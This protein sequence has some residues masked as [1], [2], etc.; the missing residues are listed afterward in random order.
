MR[1]K[2]FF[3]AGKYNLAKNA[4]N[5]SAWCADHEKLYFSPAENPFLRSKFYRK[6]LRW[7]KFHKTWKIELA[8]N[9]EYDWAWCAD[10]LNYILSHEK[11]NFQDRNF[12]LSN[13]GEENFFKI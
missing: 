5:V 2:N 1:S 12:S 6:K 7:K 3:K 11:F 13:W 4:E 8:K 9:S 10:H